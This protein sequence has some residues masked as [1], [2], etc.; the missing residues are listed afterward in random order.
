MTASKMA[1]TISA[2]TTIGVQCSILLIVSVASCE[3]LACAKVLYIP[4]VYHNAY[5]LL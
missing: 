1:I 2:T 5:A 4:R 3:C